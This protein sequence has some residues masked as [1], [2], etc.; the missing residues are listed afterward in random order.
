MRLRL[1]LGLLFVLVMSLWVPATFAQD[2]LP[3]LG[4]R[5]VSIAVENAYIP[6]NFIDEATGEAV[7]FDYDV[8]N[9]ICARINCVPEYVQTTWDALLVGVQ[10]GEFDV[11][12]SG[13]TITE[14][15]E[16]TV[17]F[18]MGVIAT[19]QVLLT[20]LGEDR[21]TTVQEFVDGDFVIGTQRGTT[22]YDKGIELVGED[23]LVA[24]EEFGPGIQALVNGDVDAVIIDSTAGQGYTGENEELLAIINEPLTSDF[25]GYAFGEGSDLVAPFDAALQS[26]MDDGTL[27]VISATWFPP[28][29]PDLGGRT[30]TIAVENAYIPFNFIDEA[31]GEAVGFDYDVMNAICARINCT[32][33]YVQTTWDALLV[34]VAAG[35]FDVGASGITITEE[36][37]QTVDFSMGVIATGQVLLTRLGEDRFASVADFVAG[38]FVIGTQR[39]TTNYDKGVELVGEDRLVAFEEF[40]P[41]IQALVNGDVDAVIID[42]TAGQGYVGENDELLSIINEPLTSDFL[43]YAFVEGS[44]LVDP[45]DAALV[46]MM[47]DGTLDEII[48]TWFN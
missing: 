34:G 21:F 13:I 18:S 26:M 38:D 32:P 6:F 30:V 11:G 12:A 43:G 23:R 31:S 35:E 27:A 9:E 1:S 28:A 33:E 3:D 29:L 41:T 5:T 44:D 17:D 20:R 37:E 42:S 39:G 19:G 48:A 7:G 8:M 47:A 36:R 4:G 22:N 15:R 25:L 24:F 2:A 16:E 14:E 10:A 40:G 45:F 46:S